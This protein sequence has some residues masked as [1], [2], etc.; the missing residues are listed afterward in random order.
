MC[1]IVHAYLE[2][3]PDRS[4]SQ[5]R[6]PFDRVDTHLWVVTA[7]SGAG[8]TWVPSYTVPNQICLE[9]PCQ[10]N[11][12]TCL[13]LRKQLV[14][15]SEWSWSP[16]ICSGDFA[17]QKSSWYFKVGNGIPHGMVS[18]VSV[19]IKR[20]LFSFIVR[21]TAVAVRMVQPLSNEWHLW[22]LIDGQ[23]TFVM[24]VIH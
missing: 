2:D 1:T 7:L 16:V 23:N 18:S 13:G 4:L 21:C 3:S 14:N 6:A 15:H 17:N 8:R 9:M 12:R 11:D 19:L 5:M 22:M 24:P 10:N 20:P